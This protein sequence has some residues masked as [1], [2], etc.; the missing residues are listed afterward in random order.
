MKKY[1][2]T[3]C[4]V[5][6]IALTPVCSAHAK[7]HH[8]GNELV[9]A[10]VGG[11]VAGL[12]GAVMYNAVNTSPVVLVDQPRYA[13]VEPMP[14]VVHAPIIARAPHPHHHVGHVRLHHRHH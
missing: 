11:A 4:L 10:A 1:F 7:Y 6:A 3:L 8:H 14:F 5:S 13:Y 9:A 2:I 12:V